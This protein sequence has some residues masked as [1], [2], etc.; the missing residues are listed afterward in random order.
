MWKKSDQAGVRGQGAKEGEKF[1]THTRCYLSPQ[2]SSSF[3][4]PPQTR[5]TRERSWVSLQSP[6][7]LKELK[8]KFKKEV[9]IVD[10]VDCVPKMRTGAQALDQIIRLGLCSEIPVILTCSAKIIL[11]HRM[12][13]FGD[14]LKFFSQKC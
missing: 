3:S 2:R 7:Q 1:G 10:E 5:R 13:R 6:E 12:N 14:S 11:S 8:G 9:L 4:T